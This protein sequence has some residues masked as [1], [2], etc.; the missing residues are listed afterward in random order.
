MFFAND[1][2][3]INT[4]QGFKSF[5]GVQIVKK[6]GQVVVSLTNGRTVK[7]SPNH[8]LMTTSGWKLAINIAHSDIIVGKGFESKVFFTDYLDGEF[9]YY[10]VVGVDTE[11]FY[12]NDILSH[13]CEFLGSSNTLI[14]PEVLRKV[15]VS[16]P[17]TSE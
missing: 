9:E 8:R 6:R 11:Q 12:A 10:D 5:A 2:L 4:P 7:C 3:R 16:S 1:K 15:S 17:N 13:N 14:S